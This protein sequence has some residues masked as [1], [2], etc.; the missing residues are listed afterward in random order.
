M[1]IY[2]N[3][4][5]YDELSDGVP[6]TEELAMTQ[7]D[8]LL[9]LRSLGVQFDAYLMDAFWF[10]P[11]GAYRNWRTPHW[12][13][14]PDRWL[15]SCQA[16]EL[17]PG[18]W[19]TANTLCQ[20]DLPEAW[21]DS[22]D[23]SGWGLCLFHGGF[24]A[25]YLD[26]LDYWY[27]RGIR[28]FKIDFADFTAAPQ[29]IQDAIPPEEIRVKNIESYRRGLRKFRAE[30]PEAIFM[31]FNGF[32]SKEFMD[33]TDRTLEPVI[34]HEW[35]ELFDSLY[36]GDPRPADVPAAPFWRS[37]D[38]YSDHT[39]RVLEHCG[40][41]LSR[42]DNCGF[43]AGPTGTCYWRGKRAWKA[44]LA[45]TYARGGDLTVLYGDLSQFDDS[46]A[47]WIS[48]VQRLYRSA[49]EKDL[50]RHIG[51][52]PGQ[53]EPYG[54]IVGP[55]AT[56]VNPSP[57]K[58]T[59]ALPAGFSRV[60]FHDAGPKPTVCNEA[61]TLAPFQ[62]AIVTQGESV[63]LGVDQTVLCPDLTSC[64][65]QLTRSDTRLREVQFTGRP[66]AFLVLVR[67]RDEQGQLVRTFP[68]VS[69]AKSL[70]LTVLVG[71]EP[72]ECELI[73]DHI[74]WSGMS[75]GGATFTLEDHSPVTVVVEWDDLR[76]ETLDIVAYSFR[77][78]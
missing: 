44:M 76:I 78:G 70:R 32:E 37:V 17:I 42:I 19:F 4:S 71:D 69:A 59:L 14:G 38:I 15:A 39:T 45:L 61:T 43:M 58:A 21:R 20:L 5:S 67:Q 31:G 9:R 25:G 34:D 47:E 40:I 10:A 30:H 64:E 74:V 16:N 29:S 60:V 77:P 8:H 75:W 57:T 3:W 24:L 6:L 50:P 54:W 68:T 7:M 49:F 62:S 28:I 53:A 48:K 27:R 72:I 35:F 65:V 33:R 56:V 36:A 1:T 63:D 73:H 12:P 52:I 55:V 23:P 22:A 66:G 51:G 46:D 2:G 13:E 41:P 18:L 11:D 26:V